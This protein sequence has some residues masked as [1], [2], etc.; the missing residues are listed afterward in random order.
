MTE[1]RDSKESIAK[2]RLKMVDFLYRIRPLTDR[3]EFKVTIPPRAYTFPN[4][5][6]KV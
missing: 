6:P 5:A 2:T 4:R 3:V 1:K